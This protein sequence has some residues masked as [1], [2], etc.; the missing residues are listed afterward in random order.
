MTQI[1]HTVGTL[2][3]NH[4]P[5]LQPTPPFGPNPGGDKCVS[6]HSSTKVVPPDGW[7]QSLA[8]IGLREDQRRTVGVVVETSLIWAWIRELRAQHDLD[9]VSSWCKMC[10][11]WELAGVPNPCWSTFCCFLSLLKHFSPLT[12]V[13]ADCCKEPYKRLVSESSA[14]HF[15]WEN[16]VPP[17]A[18]FTLLL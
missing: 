12:S 3:V 9:D 8:Q 6:S 13:D 16:F 10:Y 2:L 15:D 18:I 11:I 14:S 1:H 4:H 5:Q 7:R 17:S